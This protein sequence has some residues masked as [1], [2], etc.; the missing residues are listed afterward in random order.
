VEGTPGNPGY[1]GPPGDPG[2]PGPIGNQTI[3]QLSE[4]RYW[5]RV[6]FFDPDWAAYR[7]RVGEYYYRA[8]NASKPA[9]LPLALAEFE[10]VLRINPTNHTAQRYKDQIVQN[11]NVFGLP[12]DLDVLPRFQ[13]YESVYVN[14]APLIDR[15]FE[16]AMR[17]LDTNM[18]L[19]QKQ[20]DLQREIAN[21]TGMIGAL[22]TDLQA[23]LLEQQAA[24]R[25]VTYS[26]NRMNEINRRVQSKR[27][28]LENAQ[29]NYF[30]VILGSVALVA[31]VIAAIP[32]GGTSLIAVAPS[33]ALVAG[34]IKELPIIIGELSKPEGQR[35]ELKKL[36]AEARGLK[37]HIMKAIDVT[38]TVVRFTE[39]LNQV[40]EL[41]LDNE[42]YRKL[43]EDG[44]E[45]AHSRLLA[46][47][48]KSQADLSRESAETRLQIAK[49][50]QA[51]AEN[52]LGGLVN[53][54]RYLEGVA[55]NLLK[56]A[57]HY[58][59]MLSR[60]A[61][62]SAR[63]VEIYTL[64]DLSDQIRY[65]YG[66][67]HPDRES[68]YDGGF[69]SVAQLIGEYQ[70]SWGQHVGVVSN[71]RV[72]YDNYFRSWNWVDDFHRISIT[73]P[74]ALS[75]FKRTYGIR[76]TVRPSDLSLRLEAKVDS[77]YVAFIGATSDSGVISTVVEHS[78]L[79]Y[80]NRRDG[81]EVRI[82][83]KPQAAIAIARIVRLESPG[84]VVGSSPQNIG[85]WGKGV[86]AGWYVYIESEEL[87]AQNVDLSG[88]KEIQ[89]WIGYKS[90]LPQ[91]LISTGL[92]SLK[93]G[94]VLRDL[95]SGDVFVYEKGAKFRIGDVSLETLSISEPRID[96]VP[97][98]TLASLPT[99]PQNG[100][101]RGHDSDEIY[102][103]ID[104][105]KFRVFDVEGMDALCRR[106][107][108]VPKGALDLLVYGGEFEREKLREM[109]NDVVRDKS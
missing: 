2:Q 39:M 4:D 15:I 36:E 21:L 34:Q 100:T 91:R 31:G 23:V 78:G 5:E 20:Q 22:E 72:A 77:V 97:G 98:S 51:A 65:D 16:S 53:D 87:R 42:G 99:V 8:S 56:S 64:A 101:I 24:Q 46:V 43:L 52:Q 80:Q 74:E 19:G 6:R 14:Y 92:R 69:I 67:I 66:Y 58:M 85:F 3:T 68:D 57:Q 48:R 83:L 104:K 86:A 10:S 106:V 79:Y 45:I 55:F 107:S 95:L 35:T 89:I 75:E 84:G 33:L 25:N 88:V 28:E 61:F 41:K 49:T 94:T 63:A 62:L 1:P 54:R 30:Q 81:T 90:F 18:A 37:D 108:V 47:L 27:Q 93:D 96:D 17:M 11:E 109:I 60:Y 50:N 7:I 73:D 105:K 29:V 38:K 59:D 40:W 26:D 76:F 102:I 9:Y 71:Y 32:T 44:L 82:A 13:D 103:V 70:L 12:R